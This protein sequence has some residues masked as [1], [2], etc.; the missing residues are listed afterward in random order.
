MEYDEDRLYC[1]SCREQP[2]HFYEVMEEHLNVVT[3]E[4]ALLD[5]ENEKF[6]VAAYQCPQCK[7]RVE[8]GSH[9]GKRTRRGSR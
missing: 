8:W 4:G 5:P 2:D 3:P 6:H 7:G 1:L 9:L